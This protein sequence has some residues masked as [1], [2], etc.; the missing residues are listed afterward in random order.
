MLR[1][2]GHERVQVALDGGR[3]STVN[4]AEVLSF[5]ARQGLDTSP[6]FDRIE[7]LPIEIVPFSSAHAAL[8]AGLAPIG[9]PLGLSLGDRACLALA[10]DRGIPALTADRGWC[11]ADLGVEIMVIR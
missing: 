10:L 11:K 7:A 8:A 5:L 3:L 9:R 1:E 6:V 2:P 4:L